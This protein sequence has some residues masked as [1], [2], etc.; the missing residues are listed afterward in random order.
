MSVY[1]PLC[2]FL[3]RYLTRINSLEKLRAIKDLLK[4]CG[5]PDRGKS[6]RTYGSYNANATLLSLA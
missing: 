4:T 5:F 2:A 6:D 1:V 3:T